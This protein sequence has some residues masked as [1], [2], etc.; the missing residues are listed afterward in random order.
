MGLYD[1]HPSIRQD[2]R[3][4]MMPR[5]AS[6]GRERAV[7]LM[8]GSVLVEGMVCKGS[9]GHMTKEEERRSLLQ[10]VTDEYM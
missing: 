1:R 10:G 8:A 7:T 5:V 3:I 2:N 6:R 4:S 9:G